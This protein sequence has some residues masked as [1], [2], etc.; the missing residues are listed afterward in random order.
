MHVSVL[1]SLRAR[2]ELT[3][4]SELL[5]YTRFLFVIKFRLV[6]RDFSDSSS[7]DLITH[8]AKIQHEKSCRVAYFLC[9]KYHYHLTFFLQPKLNG[10]VWHVWAFIKSCERQLSDVSVMMFSCFWWFCRSVPFT[11]RLNTKHWKYVGGLMWLSHG[12]QSVCVCLCVFFSDAAPRL[13][14]EN[15]KYLSQLTSLM[16]EAADEQT[17]SI[18]VSLRLFICRDPAIKLSKKKKSYTWFVSVLVETQDTDLN[19]R[20]LLKM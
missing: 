17:K 19:V 6:C 10:T 7:V 14:Q 13:L 12:K 1:R 18:V 3:L 4:N 5:F 2:Q 15:Q 16:Q 20:C 9:Y 8:N 11:L